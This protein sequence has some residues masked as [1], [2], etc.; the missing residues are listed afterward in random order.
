MQRVQDNNV[1]YRYLLMWGEVEESL[2][3]A[4]N[5]MQLVERI[6]DSSGTEPI[7]WSILSTTEGSRKKR[8]KR[9]KLLNKQ[10]G[11]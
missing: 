9:V 4:G 2:W 1:K 6:T 5:Q 8:W 11:S 7:L 3:Y 10:L